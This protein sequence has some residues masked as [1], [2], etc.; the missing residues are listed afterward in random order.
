MCDKRRGNDFYFI[1]L[2]Y[3][4]A[5]LLLF[6]YNVL[7]YNDHIIFTYNGEIYSYFTYCTI[8]INQINFDGEIFLFIFLKIYFNNI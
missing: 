4:H 7:L 5:D 3:L 2:V 8:N 1:E 6:K